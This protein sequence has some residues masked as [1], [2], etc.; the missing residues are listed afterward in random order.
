MMGSGNNTVRRQRADPE[1][2]A[3]IVVG[4]ELMPSNSN[5]IERNTISEGGGGVSVI[6]S[7]GNQILDNDVRDVNGSGVVMELA[8]DN[9]VRGNDLGSNKGGIELE[10]S[11]GNRIEAN[12]ASGTLGTGIEIGALS[13]NNEVVRNT[14]NSNGGEGIAV[15]DSAPA[16][17]GN[18][19]DSNTADGNGGDGIAIDG[20]GHILKDNSA[21]MNGGWGIYAAVGAID[22]GGNF[23]AGNVEPQQCY[24]VDLRRRL[25][26]R[27]AR[28]LDRRQA[29]AAQPQPQRQL[30]LQRQRRRHPRARAR[31]RVPPR[32]QGPARLG[33]L[34]VPG[35]VPEPQPGPH[36][37]EVRAIDMLGAGLAD[38]T[39]ARYT[40]TYEPLPPNDPPEAIIDMKPEAETWLLDA[41]FTF[42]S[43]EPDVT[44]ECKVDQFGYEPCGFEQPGSCRRARFEWGLEETEV[45]PHTFY[46][47]AIDFEGN[48]GEPATYTW[49][50]LGVVTVPART[51]AGVAGF[52]PPETP[53]DPATGGETHEHHRGRS[54]SRPTSPTRPSS[55]RSTSSRSCRAPR[56]SPTRA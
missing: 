19:L 8:R 16:G 28:D 54:T 30:H 32:H 10:E 29:A 12:N 22:R 5:R 24:N 23:A 56:R 15:A 21:Q 45:G 33:G 25:G 18:L 43:N 17:Q 48:V 31:L 37:F 14:A 13:V 42:H 55:A 4:E 50:L 36:T 20:V 34:R 35:R 6:D 1:R 27:R 9:L 46:V 53:F 52:T 51:E 39:P 11:S 41:I 7:S 44:F 2:Q 49:S 3:G 26:A 40:W 47:R 38:S